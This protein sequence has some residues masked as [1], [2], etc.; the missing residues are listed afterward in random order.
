MLVQIRFRVFRGFRRPSLSAAL[1]T[2]R[3]KEGRKNGHGAKGYVS[4]FSNSG[5]P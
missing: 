5:V 4:D 2:D 3:K 1:K